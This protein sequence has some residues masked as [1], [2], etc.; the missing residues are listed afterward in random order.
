MLSIILNP[1][2][3]RGITVKYIERLQERCYF[4][5]TEVQMNT[6]LQDHDRALL[7]APN[8]LLKATEFKGLTPVE[9]CVVT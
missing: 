2:R 9:P 8:A 5:R 3:A 6:G 1:T 4:L 7:K